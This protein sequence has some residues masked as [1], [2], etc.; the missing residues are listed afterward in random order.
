MPTPIVIAS[1]V[2]IGS[3]NANSSQTT[4]RGWRSIAPSSATASVV[5]TTAMAS[6]VATVTAHCVAGPAVRSRRRTHGRTNPH[7]AA[8]R[9][10]CTSTAR[11]VVASVAV[12]PCVANSTVSTMATAPV[13]A[14]TRSQ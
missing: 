5:P 2:L 1:A 14:I 9:V 13:T 4:A 12:P 11:S 6:K 10:E 7:N 8:M 3:E